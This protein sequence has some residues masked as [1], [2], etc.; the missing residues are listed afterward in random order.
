M[1][2]TSIRNRRAFRRHIVPVAIRYISSTS[3]IGSVPRPSKAEPVVSSKR[4]C[5]LYRDEIALINL[6]KLNWD[7]V[8]YARFLEQTINSQMNLVPVHKP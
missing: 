4:N 2:S 6:F 7:M 1:H 5:I 3:K 8:Q